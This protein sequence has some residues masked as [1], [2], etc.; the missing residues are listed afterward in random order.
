MWYAQHY[1]RQRLS[2]LEAKARN[3]QLWACGVKCWVTRRFCQVQL[4]T[5]QFPQDDEARNAFPSVSGIF[6]LCDRFPKLV[7]R[8]P[9]NPPHLCQC[10]PSNLEGTTAFI[11]TAADNSLR[12]IPEIGYL[13]LHLIESLSPE[14]RTKCVGAS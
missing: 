13:E 4:L 2:N 6:G 3:P 5:S 9:V 14:Y 8:P 12:K 10:L 7:E 1:C 11:A